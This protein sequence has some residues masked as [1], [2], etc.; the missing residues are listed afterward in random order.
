M[1]KNFYST[2]PHITV[3]TAPTP[4]LYGNGPMM[5]AVR[6]NP[7]NTNYEVYDG[8]VWHVVGGSV[9]VGLSHE[10]DEALRWAIERKREEAG[11][12]ERM[13]RHPGLRDAYEKFRVMDILTQKAEEDE[14]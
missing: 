13:D 10:A 11:L 12:R 4:N 8:S 9:P 3:G 2:S 1:I 6:Y 7:G 5:G 14:L